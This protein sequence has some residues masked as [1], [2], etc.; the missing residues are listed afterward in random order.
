M[1]RNFL[2]IRKLQS[3]FYMNPLELNLCNKLDLI[4]FC[5]LMH[6]IKFLEVTSLRNYLQKPMHVHTLQHDRHI[7]SIFFSLYKISHFNILLIIIVMY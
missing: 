3:K 5:S 1:H 2:N 4:I 6:Y 7:H